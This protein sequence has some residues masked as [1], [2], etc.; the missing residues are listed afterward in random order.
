MQQLRPMG[1]KQLVLLG[2]WE[3]WV[4]TNC[5]KKSV[6]VVRA[7]C[8]VRGKRLSIAQSP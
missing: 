6:A 5:W 4:I 8:F 3:S 2:Y 1:E 7:L